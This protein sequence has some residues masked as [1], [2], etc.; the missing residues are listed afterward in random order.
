MWEG[1][2]GRGRGEKG[3]I[4]FYGKVIKLYAIVW[5]ELWLYHMP[6]LHR[7]TC[8]LHVPSSKY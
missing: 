4:A 3:F 2:G 8:S 1:G 7:S 5:S 6:S